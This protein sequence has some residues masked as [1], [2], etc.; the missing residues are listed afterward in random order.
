MR[1]LALAAA[2][3]TTVLA[4]PAMARDNSWYVGVDA[5][6]LLVEDQ[7]LTFS[8]IP[9]GGSVVPSI[10]YHKGYDFDANIGYD[11][12]GFRLEAEA[13]YKRAKIDFDKTGGG[14]G[15]AASALSFM[16]NGLL[17]FGPDDGLQGFVGGGVGVSRG[18][19]ASD[20]V[21][22][23]D[24]GFAW[25]A[26]AGV[27]YPVTNNVDVSLKYRFFNQDDIKVIPAYQSIYGEAGSTG[28]TKLRTH[29]LLLGLTYNFGGETA[30]PP[31]VAECNPGPYIVFFEWDKSDITP[32]AATILDNAVSAY[33]S[34]GSAQVMLAG[35]ADRS[36]A[37]SYN[38]GLSQRRADSTKAYL[39]SK[40]IPDG[41]ITTQAFGESKPRVDTADGVREVQNRRVE[42][43]YGPG[44]GM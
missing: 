3:A 43:S 27:R 5:G 28:D 17:D 32:D 19:L 26:I 34:C 4:T 29:S 6:V 10:D 36:G 8:S 24:T 2:L 11:F 25:Q 41:V 39:A 40:G 14:F 23:S 18:K 35:H 37:A 12:G 7:D 33:S 44:A 22:D 21:N 9:P 38:V 31:P 1:K 30:P 16:L 20:I 13:A 42:I 15:G